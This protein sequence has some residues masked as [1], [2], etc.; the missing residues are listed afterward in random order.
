MLCLSPFKPRLVTVPDGMQ[1]EGEPH[2]KA[3]GSRVE[4]LPPGTWTE[5]G[6][7]T[8]TPGIV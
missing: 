6:Q 3:V 4:S 7:T 1:T 2:H 8:V 5:S